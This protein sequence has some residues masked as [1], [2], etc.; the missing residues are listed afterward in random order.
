MLL[1]IAT[2]PAMLGT[3]EAIH[4]GQRKERREEHRARRCNLVVSCTKS[5]VRSRDINGRPVVLKNNKL[6]INTGFA[7]SL[8]EPS[9]HPF[10]GYF[11]PYPDTK[12][13]GLV[14]TITNVAP[15]LNWI[16]VDKDT[17]EI[18]YNV[19]AEAQ[20]HLTGPFDCTRQDRRLTFES[21]EGFVAVEELPAVWALYF[22]R[23]D[24][25]LRGKVPRGTRVLE[26]TL[27]R[28]ERKRDKGDADREKEEARQ[29]REGLKNPNANT[30]AVMAKS[31]QKREACIDHPRW[32]VKR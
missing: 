16:Y 9:A 6:Y 4:Q 18:K 30:D 22:D 19:R 26:I 11:L 31:S 13:E 2:L 14:S 10:A 28:T 29:A 21:W 12:Y 24:N 23:D 7:T 25:G 1:A 3:Q 8:T 15:I 17:Y 5:S 20:P 27:T 32:N